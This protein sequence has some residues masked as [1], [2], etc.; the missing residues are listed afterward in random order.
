MA[1][2]TDGV[3]QTCHSFDSSSAYA[4]TYDGPWKLY[5]RCNIF[6]DLQNEQEQVT[7]DTS[8]NTKSNDEVTGVYY[9][10]EYMVKF[11][12][13]SL[14]TTFVN[15]EYLYIGSI[16][17]FET[18]QPEYLRN[19]TK[20]KNINIP[21]NSVKKLNA[22]VFAETNNLEPIERQLVD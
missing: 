7:T 4:N 22:Q 13:N 15:L 3:T 12:P 10:P 19:A 6:G 21:N 1:G 14:F 17:K 16:N 11:V 8:E 5:Y 2:T 18:L 20:L 9:Y